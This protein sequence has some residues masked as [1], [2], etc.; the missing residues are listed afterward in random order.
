MEQKSDDVNINFYCPITGELMSD[1]V[2]DHEGN[3]YERAAI[4]ARLATNQTSP[5][6]GH[7]LN[8]SNLTPNRALK[9]AIESALRS[10][11]D[12]PPRRARESEDPNINIQSLNLS[13]LETDF[14]FKITPGSVNISENGEH[15]IDMLISAL[16]AE[17]PTRVPT[18]I[19]CVVDVSGSMGTGAGTPGTESAALTILDIVKHALVT[20]INTLNEE[21]RL[22]LVCYSSYAT[23]VF[24]LLPM[25]AMGKMRATNLLKTLRPDGMT[26]IWDGLKTGLDVLKA[27]AESRVTEG[28][29]S[30]MLL[31]DGVPNKDPPKPYVQM[32]EDYRR[33]Y[34]GRLPGAIT[35]FGFGYQLNSP[36]LMTLCVSGGSHYGFIPDSGMVGTAFVNALANILSTS[37]K[38]SV[39]TLTAGGGAKFKAFPSG[40]LMCTN[41]DEQAAEPAETGAMRGIQVLLGDMQMGQSRDVLVKMI[42]P[43]AT[44]LNTEMNI[45]SAV[46]VYKKA[47]ESAEYRLEAQS[48]PLSSLQ[49]EEAT[50]VSRRIERANVLVEIAVQRFRTRTVEVLNEAIR[51][52]GLKKEVETNDLAAGRALIDSFTEELRSWLEEEGAVLRQGYIEGETG[53]VDGFGQLEGLLA[54]LEGQ[55]VQ[56]FSRPDWYYKWGVHYIPSLA[57]A[58][59]LQQ[60]SNFKDPGVQHYGGSV[61]R[62]VRDYA[63]EVFCRLPP[64]GAAKV[65]MAQFNNR[66]NPCFHGDCLVRMSN[67]EEKRVREIEKGDRVYTGERDEIGEIECVLCTEVEG[68]EM[69]LIE[70]PARCEREREREDETTPLIITPWHPVRINGKWQFPIQISAHTLKR[71]PCEAVY[72]FVLC[73]HPMREKEKEDMRERERE[74]ERGCRRSMV[75]GGYEVATLGH[76][77]MKDETVSHEFF[78]TETVIE[79]LRST[80]EAG[81]RKGLIRLKAGAMRR[82]IERNE[83]ECE[84]EM[85]MI[86]GRVCGI[87]HGYNVCDENQNK[88]D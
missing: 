56:A 50:E 5:K 55:G 24:G 83:R 65:N 66:D 23:V 38:D 63:D 41:L 71:R 72:S 26:N 57:R 29:A 21:D 2:I 82:E 39:L 8:L 20:I 48:G 64:P 36:L 37:I 1:P 62:D 40:S 18:D 43:P 59:Q 87:R 86:E 7:P 14:P 4:E 42:V 53:G 44:A 10:G 49:Y 77:L 15:E 67:G 32:L 61:F 75:I 51:L 54:D 79:C 74:S 22:A 70:I 35:T 69:E 9:S 80:C 28:N 47:G 81:W 16:P 12:L 13:A 31:T 30:I 33:T 60:C 17:R 88:R 46:L 6:T 3:S 85:K 78:G 19:C 25:S 58:H 84:S 27:G 45:L 73:K 34:N 11:E 76:G 52:G 68:G